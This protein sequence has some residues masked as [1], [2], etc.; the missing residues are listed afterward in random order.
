M[1][2]DEIEWRLWEC[3]RTTSER[4]RVYQANLRAG[5]NPPRSLV[6]HL[7]ARIHR[8]DLKVRDSS[9]QFCKKAAVTVSIDESTAAWDHLS[10]SE[11]S[12]SLQI[13]AKAK[14]FHPTIQAGETIEAGRCTH[15][16]SGS[17]MSKGRRAQAAASG[18]R[19]RLR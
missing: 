1:G 14:V 7:P 2:D 3:C 6:E 12:A 15:G 17:I 18:A 19:D 11:L 13:R 8:R 16:E 4:I 10:Y 5:R 9:R